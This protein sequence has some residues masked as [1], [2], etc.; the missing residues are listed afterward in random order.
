M[1]KCS[2]DKQAGVLI[3]IC[4]IVS[5]IHKMGFQALPRE[6]MSELCQVFRVSCGSLFAECPSAPSQVSAAPL[7]HCG[8]RGRH[9]PRGQTVSETF[10]KKP[11]VEG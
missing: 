4:S 6:I 3:D 2:S 1:K 10:G 11:N 7:S 5:S 8:T 9:H